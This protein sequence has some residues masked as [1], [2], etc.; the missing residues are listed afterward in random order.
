MKYLV[1]SVT[2]KIGNMKATELR[3]GM[4]V[5]EVF[6]IGKRSIPMTVVGIYSSLAKLNTDDC[7]VY[8]D[9][10]GNEG[11]MYEVKAIDLERVE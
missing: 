11:E 5:C 4:K 10:E 1:L 7:D 3:I 6:D 2:A 9:F 8:L